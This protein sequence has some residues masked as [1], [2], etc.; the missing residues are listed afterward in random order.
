[1]PRDAATELRQVR[2][3]VTTSRIPKNAV[4]CNVYTKAE[5]HKL[6]VPKGKVAVSVA[7][8]A[9]HSVGGATGVGSY[10]DVYVQ[11]DGVTDRLCGAYVIDT[12]G[13]RAT[14]E[15]KIEWVT[16]AATRRRQGTAGSLGQGNGQLDDSRHGAR[17]KERR[18]R[19]MKAIWLA[20]CACGDYG[21]LQRE[22]EGRDAACRCFAW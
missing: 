11:K 9:E 6:E 16:L 14:R 1:M 17:Q 15:G 19:V 5:S 8:D 20:C 2:G 21:L 12:S 13:F 7:V 18:R 3:D 10:V 4:I 22:V